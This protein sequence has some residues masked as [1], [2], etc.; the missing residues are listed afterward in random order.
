MNMN[1]VN[2]SEANVSGAQSGSPRPA[3]AEPLFRFVSFGDWVGH[4]TQK[5]QRAGVKG[6]DVVC[7]DS[8]GRVCRIGKD[9]MA[10]DADGAF[11]VTAY[12]R[13]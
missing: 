7:L 6:K 3:Q 5:F 13:S 2:E 8:K 4:A 12:R 9:F 1:S 11:P 10:A